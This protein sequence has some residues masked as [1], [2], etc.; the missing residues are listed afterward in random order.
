MIA[1][2][3]RL[4]QTWTVIFLLDAVPPQRLVLLKRAA[5]K[6]FAPDMY[7]GIGGKEEHNEG[8]LACALREL[9]E[10]TGLADVTL[11]EFAHCLLDGEKSLHYYWGIAPQPALPACTEGTLEWVTTKD[12][13]TL[14]IIPTTLEVLKIWQ[15]NAF[16][17]DMYF[18]VYEKSV[19]TQGTMS[20][21]TVE[22]VIFGK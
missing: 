8:P 17:T 11:N 18:T 2:R 13:L 14:P 7:T 21:V 9:E 6:S 5:W 10:E 19:G 4:L 15:Q 22:K 3:E 20:L 12:L 16:S 1:T